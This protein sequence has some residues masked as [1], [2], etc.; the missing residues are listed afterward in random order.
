MGCTAAAHAQGLLLGGD[1][2]ASLLVAFPTLSSLYLRSVDVAGAS[3]FQGL[4][5]HTSL[6]A[7]SL[8]W[9]TWAD[10]SAQASLASIAQLPALTSL[11]LSGMQA[12]S[13]DLAFLGSAALCGGLDRTLTRLDLGTSTSE[14]RA[15]FARL[16]R[17][18]S[19]L[20]AL[21][22]GLGVV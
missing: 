7:L 8:S 22:V 16:A 3:F 21:Q 12:Q 11:S 4:P 20:R 15:P 13:T 9:V 19:Q 10:A 18:V 17:S 5:P 1:L 14:H 6:T 2:A